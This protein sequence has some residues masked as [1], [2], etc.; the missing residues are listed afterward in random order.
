MRVPGSHLL[1]IKGK[2]TFMRAGQ[3]TGTRTKKKWSGLLR[4]RPSLSV[5]P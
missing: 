5:V 4:Q 3:K 2:P 1:H